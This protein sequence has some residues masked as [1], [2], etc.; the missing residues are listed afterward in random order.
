MSSGVNGGLFLSLDGI[1]GTGKSTQCRLLVEWLTAQGL[2]A[3][4]CSD[5]G[6]TE[7]GTKLRSLLL[8][9]R[10]DMAAVTEAFLFLASRAELTRLV[11]RPA[12]ERGE[13]VVADR[14]T[15]A[16]VVYQGYGADL[17]PDLIRQWSNA[18]TAGLQP[19]TTFLL[20]LPVATAA[21][22]LGRVQDRMEAKGV[23]F[24][25]KLRQGFLHEAGKYPDAIRV[26]D[27]SGS[28]DELQTRLRQT[29]S[30]ILTRCNAEAVVE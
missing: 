24:F 29:V 2:A 21:K 16:N 14:F 17:D 19:A 3:R 13:V 4:V 1:D 22:R 12:L 15:L 23:A 18:A 30:E 27:A 7:L 5:P 11:I 9:H 26:F 8:D 10:H 28:I 25:E 6:G 20:D